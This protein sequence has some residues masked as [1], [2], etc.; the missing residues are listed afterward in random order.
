MSFAFV[1]REETWQFNDGDEPDVRELVDVD[2]FD[3]SVV[4]FPAYPDTS[5]AV[6][7]RSQHSVKRLPK[8]VARALH[9]VRMAEIESVR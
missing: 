1:A 8:D 9:V 6:R 4:T 5:V 7:S 2:L 3:V